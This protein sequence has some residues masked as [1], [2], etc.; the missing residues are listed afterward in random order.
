MTRT[1]SAKEKLNTRIFRAVHRR[2]L[3]YNTCWEDPALDR[4]ALDLRPDDRVLVI[5]S[6]GCNALDYLLAGAGEVNAVDMNPIQNA[7]LELKTAAVRTLDYDSFFELFGQGRSPQTRQMY[8]D[9]LRKELSPPARA[10][11]DKHI[12]F[13][14]GKSWR[15]SFYYRGTSGLLAKLLLVNLQVLHRLREPIEQLLEARTIEEQREIYHGQIRHRIWKPWLRWF[16]RQSVTL[17]LAGVPWPQRN[18]I[19]TQY[20]GGVPQFVH[21]A[22]EAVVTQLPFHDNYFWRVYIQ[23]NY[24]PTC[25]PEYLK[26]ANFERLRGLLPRL[27]IHTSTV[28]DFVRRAEPGVSKFVLLDHMD[29]MSFYNPESLVDEWNAILEKARPGARVIYRSAGLKVSYLDH[30][31]VRYRGE[32]RELGG[33]LR[34]NPNL[35]AELHARDRV[36]TYG[37]FYIADLPDGGRV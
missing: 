4:V 37:S 20:P 13:F 36:H 18:E 11:W 19:T 8:G 12:S 35:V 5:T 28:T 30:L 17:S 31:R 6:A 34:Q 24:T 3:I 21:D 9:V 22:V 16:L 32:E 29:W 14:V 10:Y 27:K 2:N 15:K 23:G 7:L 25:C 33:L 1:S 26:Q